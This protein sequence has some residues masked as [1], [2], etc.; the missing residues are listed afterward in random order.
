MI[1]R[2]QVKRN[3]D[4][5]TLIELLIVIV[6]LGILAAIV[7]FAVGSTRKDSVQ[8]SCKTNVKAVELSAEA[9][10]TN[11]GT[12]PIGAS[13]ATQAQAV[14]AGILSPAAGA[15]LKTW[16][17]GGTDYTIEYKGPATAAAAALAGGND[18]TIA[19]HKTS[20]VTTAYFGCG[21]I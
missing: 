21:G 13:V 12:Y 8:A 2:L 3:E 20:D 4:G 6:V 5:F 9:V 14:S 7:V 16:P 17:L 10:N 19:V 18:Y 1:Q 15:L 11:V